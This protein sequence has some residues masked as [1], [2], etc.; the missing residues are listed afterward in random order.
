M[1]PIRVVID[2]LT[3]AA[4]VVVAA[5]VVVVLVSNVER[6]RRSVTIWSTDHWCTMYRVSWDEWTT[7]CPKCKEAL[8][9]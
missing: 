1:G 2:L 4:V 9:R 5:Y 6:H 3:V 8:E 7:D